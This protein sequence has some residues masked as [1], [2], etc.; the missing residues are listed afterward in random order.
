MRKRSGLG[1]TAKIEQR[2]SRGLISLLRP[3][4]ACILVTLGLFAILVNVVLSPILLKQAVQNAERSLDTIDV[5]L[6]DMQKSARETAAY[7]LLSESCI[8]LLNATSPKSITASNTVNGLRQLRLFTNSNSKVDSISIMNRKAG[9]IFSTQQIPIITSSKNEEIFPEWLTKETAGTFFKRTI[10]TEVNNKMLV[11][12][13]DVY[14]YV[15]PNIYENGILQ[16]AVV[17]NLSLDYLEDR[18]TKSFDLST[19][20]LQITD[21]Q[22]S[23]IQ[24]DIDS[25]FSDP[26]VCAISHEMSEKQLCTKETTIH[27][28]RWLFICKTSSLPNIRL[29]AAYKCSSIYYTVYQI[30][31]II[32]ILFFAILL[33]GVLLSFGTSAFIHSKIKEKDS[34]YK[35]LAAQSEKNAAFARQKFWQDYMSFRGQQTPEQLTVRI[36]ELHLDNL[37]QGHL[38]LMHLEFGSLSDE[39]TTRTAEADMLNLFLRVFHRLSPAFLFSFRGDYLFLLRMQN[40]DSSCSMTTL[41]Q[42]FTEESVCHFELIGSENIVN[43][44]EYPMLWK[45]FA[46]A[47]PQMFFYPIDSYQLL[48]SVLKDHKDSSLKSNTNLLQRIPLTVASGDLTASL[49]LFEQYESSL[50]TKTYESYF[51]CITQVVLGIVDLL[52]R[53][54]T[55]LLIDVNEELAFDVFCSAAKNCKKVSL[56]CLLVQKYITDAVAYLNGAEA[57]PIA[58]DKASQIC[59]YVRENYGSNQLT[60]VEIAERFGVSPDYLRKIFK[61][62]T[63]KS[64]SE[65]ISY[66][67]LTAAA[68]LIRSSDCAFSEIAASC[69]FSNINYFYTCFKKFYGVT[70]KAYR[71]IQA[72]NGSLDTHATN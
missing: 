37:C 61:A 5:E 43:L 8:P 45:Q 14:T 15:A 26:A 60:N 28:E 17:V 47:V 7:T 68:D 50:R 51:N 18:I 3:I 19:S 16:S 29:F 10:M 1:L 39:S 46:M 41:A 27:G 25:F 20:Y 59:D 34:A 69:G 38:V 2:I 33:L 71:T 42:Q 31:R 12:P 53:K 30:Q 72:T 21:E 36:H 23:I 62:A 66:I 22:N 11:A 13:H 70:P 52:Q 35:T 55:L 65:Y 44:D 4:T 57:A 58:K 54:Q 24:F 40:T 32:V 63:G 64:L 67:R 56:L 48:S 9:S 49:A 6:S